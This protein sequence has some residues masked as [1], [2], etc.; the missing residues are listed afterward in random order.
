M[1]RSA[2]PVLLIACTIVAAVLA[3]LVVQRMF[4][5]GPSDEASGPAVAETRAL[6]A[7]SK[8]DVSGNAE[9][10]LV[11]GDRHEV[12]VEAAA[13]DQDRIRT[14]VDGVTLRIVTGKRHG[15]RAFEG[16]VRTPRIV[17][18]APTFESIAAAGAIRISSPSLNVA[19]LRI[20]AAGTTTLR[21]DS[22]KA[23][24]LRIAGS[25]AVKADLAGKVTDLAISLSGA[26]AIRAP[27]LVSETAKVSVAGAGVVVVNAEK[28][29]RV[30]LSGAGSVEYL[31]NPEVKQS[32]SGLGRVKR[33]DA[34]TA[35]TRTRFQVALA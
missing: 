30:S 35:P 33:R 11:Q 26:G 32:V 7:F 28:S 9:I 17:V 12:V 24:S 21:F 34:D 22:L 19:S 20:A 10:E 27:Q 18:R 15:W 14:E 29:L 1:R 13:G 31:G 6:G 16:P 25:G 2:L 8:I 5:A 3:W 4:R 23:D